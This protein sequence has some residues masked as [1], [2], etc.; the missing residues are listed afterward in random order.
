MILSC[1]NS[2]L[3]VSFNIEILLDPELTKEQV[4]MIMFSKVEKLMCEWIQN[5]SIKGICVKAHELFV[6]QL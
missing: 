5:E 1:S 6:D 3:G 2:V 4:I